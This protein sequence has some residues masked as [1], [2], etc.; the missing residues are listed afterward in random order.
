[1][2]GSKIFKIMDKDCAGVL[3]LD[4][5]TGCLEPVPANFYDQ[6]KETLVSYIFTQK[7]FEISQQSFIKFW[8]NGLKKPMSV[9]IDLQALLG[10][11]P[12]NKKPKLFSSRLLK[13]L[14]E[15]QN[16]SVSLRRILDE[17][18]ELCEK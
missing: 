13:R 16:A 18:E 4:D 14:K 6:V 17:S 9:D 8:D 11:E 2:D 3:C 7:S 10:N 15:R 1:M 5:L 12:C